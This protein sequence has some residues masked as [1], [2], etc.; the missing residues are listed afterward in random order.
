MSG[1]REM[2][3]FQARHTRLNFPAIK[4]IPYANS[5]AEQHCLTLPHL[6]I[7][8]GI[9]FFF[10]TLRAAAVHT[11]K[12][13]TTT[14]PWKRMEDSIHETHRG[15]CRVGFVLPLVIGQFFVQSYLQEY[16]YPIAVNSSA[17]HRTNLISRLI[18][19]K[20]S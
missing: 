19:F 18:C 16:F 14:A 4:G 11:Y 17:T 13:S 2:V 8:Y 9:F 10:L 7:P 12:W 5:P 1:C 6:A 15:R 3:F 20:M